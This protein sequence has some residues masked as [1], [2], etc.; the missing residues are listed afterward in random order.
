[1][2]VLVA[3]KF[4]DIGLKGIGELGVEV[5]YQPDLKGDE[6]G[7]KLASEGYDVLVVRSTEVTS[8]MISVSRLGLII[9]AGAGTNT[10]DVQA[11]NERGVLVSN[12]PG[13]N[14]LAV[15]EL[16]FGLMIACDRRIPDNVQQLR[17]GIWN[18]KEYSKGRGL[19]TRTLGLI[20]MGNI[21][22]EMI[23]RARAFGMYVVANSRWMTPETAAALGIGRAATIHELARQSDYVSVHLSLTP[24]TKGI[25]NDEF[26]DAMRE[27]T[28]FINTSRGEVVDQAA[29]LRALDRKKI[30][31]G[32]DVFEGEPAGGTGSYDG[33]LRHHPKVFCTHHIG[34]ST[35]QAQEA[36]AEETV[37]I[38][39]DYM[40]T[41]RVPNAVNVKKA[42][43]SSHLLVVR[44]A[45][46]VGVLAHI[47]DVLQSEGVSVQ[48]M[49]NVILGG[50]H[51]AIAQL[52]LDKMPST[53]SIA[54][55]KLNANVFD[56]SVM[57]I[58][59]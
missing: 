4:E 41:G 14:S 31:A 59:K 8:A 27:N 3:D 44:H 5:S 16:A 53:E 30:Y 1:M 42:D 47:L 15:A 38:V 36:I 56:I 18:K 28:V 51:A 20:G 40:L 39:K 7:D 19:A 23:P 9:R 6:L 45:D 21:S 50:A 32:L 58:R 54:N 48:E 2:K 13:K 52:A 37:R 29:L 26:F 55:M 12:C 22:Q 33:P 25:I 10:I 43:K 24:E 11:A 35:E 17:E 57:A 49:E 34:A 46:R